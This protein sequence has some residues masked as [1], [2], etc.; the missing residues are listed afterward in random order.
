[1][2]GVYN[3]NIRHNYYLYSPLLQRTLQEGRHGRSIVRRYLS[4]RKGGEPYIKSGRLLDP[5]HTGT[6]TLLFQH[7]LEVWS[8]HADLLRRPGDIPVIAVKGTE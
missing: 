3:R 1:M 8:L 4:R 5:P 6:D 7:G 2:V